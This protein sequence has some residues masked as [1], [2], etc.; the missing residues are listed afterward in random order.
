MQ[1]LFRRLLPDHPKVVDG[2][3]VARLVT[4]PALMKPYVVLSYPKFQVTVV[5]LPPSLM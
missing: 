2:T 4:T 1:G 5:G 3:S